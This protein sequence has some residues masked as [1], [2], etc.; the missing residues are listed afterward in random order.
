MYDCCITIWL[1]SKG[2]RTPNLAAA[3]ALNDLHGPRLL[4]KQ[5][6]VPGPFS[7]I[8]HVML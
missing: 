6:T 1:P 3:V 7:L 8:V 2:F 5:G 4:G